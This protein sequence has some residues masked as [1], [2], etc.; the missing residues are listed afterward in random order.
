MESQAYRPWNFHGRTVLV[1][2]HV[3]RAWE[4][5]FKINLV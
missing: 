5:A 2:K 4:L 3:L 1:D